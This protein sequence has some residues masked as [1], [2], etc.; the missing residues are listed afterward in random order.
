MLSNPSLQYTV[1]GQHMK[2]VE[3]TLLDIA[4]ALQ[5]SE[6]YVPLHWVRKHQTDFFLNSCVKKMMR[7]R[8]TSNVVVVVCLH[9]AKI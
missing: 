8:V 3:G 9:T 7:Q 2:K 5:F 1:R 6:A 4:A